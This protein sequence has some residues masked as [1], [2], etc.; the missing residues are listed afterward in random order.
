MTSDRNAPS[1]L[2]L[3][4]GM[5]SRYGGLKQVD[6]VG[7]HGETL[8]D[9]SLYDAW[10][11]GFSRVV[12]LIR[13][14]MH[15]IFIQQIAQKYAGRI[16]VAYAFQEVD[17]LPAELHFSG[18]REKPWG[19]GH[20]VWCAR[21]A[22]EGRSFAVINADDFYGSATFTALIDAIFQAD[23]LP[24]KKNVITGSIIGFQL[25]QTLS[26]H[27]S[28]SRGICQINE[29]KLSKVEEWSAI[30]K[31]DHGITGKNSAGLFDKLSGEE[32]VSMNVWAFSASVFSALK[33]GMIEF[34]ESSSDL[35]TDEYYLP[36]AVD[37]W[38]ATGT[39]VFEVKLA[40][41]QWMGVTYQED[42]PLVVESIEK[43]I[44]HGDYPS[45]L[46]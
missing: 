44:Y 28:V 43:M 34:F 11:A 35:A 3:A 19:T 33:D 4:A 8:M 38:I 41:C 39:A 22:L 45:P 42:K 15:E 9:Y 20:A 24:E 12:F 36:T 27:G 13:E 16:E 30:C 7:P 5:G 31:T 25:G 10:K 17:D 18:E 26:D 32:V 23:S 2:V 37:H 29:G 40:S 1:L 21:H 6:P 14:E 46:F